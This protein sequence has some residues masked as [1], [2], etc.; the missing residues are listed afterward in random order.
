MTLKLDITLVFLH[1]IQHHFICLVA[2]KY[3]SIPHFSYTCTCR[4]HTAQGY[5]L[6]STVIAILVKVYFYENDSISFTLAE[7]PFFPVKK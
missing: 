3:K 1:V 5:L 6:F 7:T 2:E 4:P